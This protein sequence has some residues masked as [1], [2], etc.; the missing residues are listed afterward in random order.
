MKLNNLNIDHQLTASTIDNFFNDPQ[1]IMK[2]RQMFL[3]N[4]IRWQTGRVIELY[5]LYDRSLWLIENG[6]NVHMAEYFDEEISPRNIGIL[7]TI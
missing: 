7:A 1:T 4:I 2:V 3:D 6:F 5:I